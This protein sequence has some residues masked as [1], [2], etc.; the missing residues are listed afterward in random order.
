MSEHKITVRYCHACGKPLYKYVIESLPLTDDFGKGLEPTEYLTR[1]EL[2]V[3][4]ML[5]QGKQNKEMAD[6]LCISVKT[7]EKHRKWQVKS[8]VEILAKAYKHHLFI[9]PSL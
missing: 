2:V 3:M 5:C 4:R 9:L 1:Q 8:A 6:L 7:V